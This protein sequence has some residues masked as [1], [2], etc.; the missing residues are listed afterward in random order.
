MPC[1]ELKVR[2]SRFKVQSL[3]TKANCAA[4][5]RHSTPN[6]GDFSLRFERPEEK[7]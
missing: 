1:A 5:A 2:G 3:G 7:L 4:F 6:A